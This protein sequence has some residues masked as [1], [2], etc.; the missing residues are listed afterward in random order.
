MKKRLVVLLI[1]IAAAAYCG[2]SP[3]WSGTV[4][5]SWDNNPPEEQVTHYTVYSRKKGDSVTFKTDILVADIPVD[6]Q[7]VYTKEFPDSTVQC[8]SATATN[9]QGESGRTNEICRYI[10]MP[11][12]PQGI[13][14]TIKISL[15][16]I[17]P[18][19]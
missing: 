16:I 18:S 2:T 13:E 8:F 3:A 9:A 5:I 10:G 12:T 4:N 17:N 1:S 7:P 6:G 11:N 19:Q 15:A 14:V